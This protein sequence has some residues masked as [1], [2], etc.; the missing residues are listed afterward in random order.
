MVEIQ[1]TK[2]HILSKM[3]RDIFAIPITTIA[4]ES[5]FNAGGRAIDPYHA[6]LVT[7]TVEMLLCSSNWVRALHG[8]K[9]II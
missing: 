9:K 7:E 5:T 8:L 2:Y 4:S 6:F 1:L 3:A